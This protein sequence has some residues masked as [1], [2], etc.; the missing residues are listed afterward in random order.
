M[1]KLPVEVSLGQVPTKGANTTTVDWGVVVLKQ[2][3]KQVAPDAPLL[4]LRKGQG[5]SK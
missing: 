4:G 3:N 5:H 1:T 2:I